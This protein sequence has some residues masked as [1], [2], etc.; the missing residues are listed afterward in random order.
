MILSHDQDISIVETGIMENNYRFF[1]LARVLCPFCKG[2]KK[3]IFGDFA[4]P[5]I[6]EN[7]VV[8]ALRTTDC[9]CCLISLSYQPGQC[10]VYAWYHTS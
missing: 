3:F 1:A 9:C 7:K 2:W 6:I 10:L 5:I 8:A 4:S